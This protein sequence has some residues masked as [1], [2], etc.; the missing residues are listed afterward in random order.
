MR[1][2]DYVKSLLSITDDKLDEILGL[3]IEIV[4]QQILNYCNIKELPEDLKF[5]AAMMVVDLH[6]ELYDE[7]VDGNG[8][9]GEITGSVSTVSEA[10]RTV[11]FDSSKA[12]SEAALK[13]ALATMA[14]EQKIKDRQTQL[15]RFKQVYA[16]R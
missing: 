15:D 12:S 6:K 9:A 10:G 7:P 13:T 1:I 5:V 11:S 4:T 2:I 14:A 8:G 3:Y 16:F